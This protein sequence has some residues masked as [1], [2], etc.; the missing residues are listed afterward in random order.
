MFIG[1]H[2]KVI[3]LK[4]MRWLAGGTL[5]IL[6]A[7]VL[8]AAVLFVLNQKLSHSN[9]ILRQH[10][11]ATQTEMKKVR[12]QTDLLMAQLAVAQVKAGEADPTP[13]A[14]ESDTTGAGEETESAPGGTDK[15]S[16]S[17][18]SSS[19][20]QKP[21]T[22][23][24]PEPPS[25]P[26]SKQAAGKPPAADKP[27]SASPAGEASGDVM[28]EIDN[29]EVNAPQGSGTLKLEFKLRNVS[30]K[31]Q[32]IEGRA[33]AILK[34]DNLSPAQWITIPRVKLVEGRPAEQKGY[35]FAINNWRTMRLR[36]N[37]SGSIERYNLVEIY[38]FSE[39]GDIWLR[40]VH[41][42]PPQ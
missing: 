20:G 9:R 24:A 11:E 35:R 39:D 12:Q 3:E 10:L 30:P 22:G 34:G 37:F 23:P 17:P 28:V 6:M 26:E 15:P 36:T 14:P 8:A 5:F 1:D 42:V 7:A 38:V 18:S 32:R 21:D 27:E 31:P 40:E 25:E 2:G 33:L 19:P 16:E 29:L 4:H 13:A 41:A